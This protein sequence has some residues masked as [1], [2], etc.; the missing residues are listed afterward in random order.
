MQRVLFGFDQR[1]LGSHLFL[2]P[3]IS[4]QCV[5]D[6]LECL[7]DGEGSSELRQ[8]VGLG[9]QLV[10]VFESATTSVPVRFCN[11]NWKPPMAP[12]PG[13]GGGLKLV[14]WAVGM[15]ANCR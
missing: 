11:S 2:R 14:I 1:L 4:D 9:N 10:G 3:F 5:V 15:A 8:L 7:L 6:F 13:M 12:S